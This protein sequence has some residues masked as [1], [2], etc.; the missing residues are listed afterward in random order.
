MGLWKQLFGDI[1]T[2]TIKELQPLVKKINN[3]EPAVQ[4]LADSDFPKK[5]AELKQRLEKGETLDAILPEAFALAREASKRTLGLRPYDVQL[6][7]GMVIHRGNIAEMRTGE[8]KTLVAVLPAYL[9]ALAGRGVHVVTTNDYLAKRDADWMGQVYNFL[10]LTVGALAGQLQSFIYDEK[11]NDLNQ[12]SE[13]DEQ[14]DEQGSFKVFGE[15]LRPCQRVEAYAADITYGT[16]SEFGFDYLRDNTQYEMAGVVQRDPFFA[17]VDEIDSILVDEARVPLILSGPADQATDAYMKFAEVASKLEAETHFAVDEKSKTIQLN[18][19]GITRAEEILVIQNLYSP[20]HIKDIHHL[21]TAVRAKANFVRDREYVVTPDQ[22]VVI[23]DPSTGRMQPGRRWSEGLHQ[24]IEAKEGAPIQAENRTVAS[25]TYQNYFK[26]YDKLSGMTGT[27]ITSAEE[28]RKVYGLE[29]IIVPTNKPIARLDQQDLIFQTELG[30]F[31]AIARQVQELQA[32]GQPTLV[33]TASVEKSELLSE[34]LKKENVKHTVL[35]AKHH[36]SEGEVIAQ[37]G[38]AGSVVIATNMAGRGVDIKLG[39]N[40]TTPELEQEI[41]DLG[42]LFVLGTER[43]E[44]RRIDNQLRGRSG[45]QGDPGE[46]QFYVSME[47]TV[48]RVFG[49]DRVKALIGALGIPEDQ[50][51]QNKMISNTLERAQKKI[52]DFHFDGRKQVLEYDN[53]L[54]HHRTTVYARR[55]KILLNDEEF[56][57]DFFDRVISSSE[58]GTTISEKRTE[59]GDETFLPMFRRAALFVVDRLWMEHLEVMESVKSSVSLRAYGQREPIVEYK[60]EGL[61]LFQEMENTLHARVAEFAVNIDVEAIQQQQ[62][63]IQ[64]AREASS[65]ASEIAAKVL[66]DAGGDKIGR[67]DKITIEKDGKTQEIK[68]KKFEEY[69]KDGW[70]V[71][72]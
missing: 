48:M 61:R 52:E 66:R 62:R 36:E 12:D 18:D 32:K 21:E 42:G 19:D 68:F 5:T 22:K 35:N 58:Q 30:K 57:S 15:Y 69:E 63:D 9:N 49:G 39:G 13:T 2:K 24:A 71:K 47:D 50:P 27:A 23:V 29:V 53:V 14:R 31:D 44:S 43:H 56:L 4:S 38:K 20:E 46:T 25:I 60:K 34:K 1:S 3:F 8:G 17:I 51:V 16:N 33:G 67:N 40:P 6:V 10:G 28:F 72:K 64:R 7:G 59:L 54:S 11:A 26:F 70:V 55:K 37:A 41:K 65:Q 45:R